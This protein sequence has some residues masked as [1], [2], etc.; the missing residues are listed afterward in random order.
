MTSIGFGE[1]G[2]AEILTP[3][4]RAQSVVISDPSQPDMPVIFVSE[5]FQAHTGYAPEDVLG[6]NCRFLQ[7]LHTDPAAVQAIRH[8][9]TSEDEITVDLAN[10][11]KDGTLFWNRLRIRP[12]FGDDSRVMFYIGAQNPIEA[13]QVRPVP[14][15]GIEE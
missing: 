2:R 4:E 3:E 8:A 6:R 12:H 7:G 14:I 9:L 15:E 11:R 13:D 1:L 5:E 10:S